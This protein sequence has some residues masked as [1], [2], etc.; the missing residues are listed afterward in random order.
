[1]SYTPPNPQPPQ[2]ERSSSLL[3][4]NYGYPKWGPIIEIGRAHV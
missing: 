2:H 1:M 3:L 4:E